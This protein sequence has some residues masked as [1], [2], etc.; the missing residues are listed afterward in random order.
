MG[1]LGSRERQAAPGLWLWSCPFTPSRGPRGPRPCP[2]A[3]G[4][5]PSCLPTVA[6]PSRACLTGP[7]TFR[8][9]GPAL[10]TGTADP[11]GSWTAP[12]LPP[13]QSRAVLDSAEAGGRRAEG[14]PGC[15][16]REDASLS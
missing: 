13:V 15:R 10:E 9:R 7:S 4:V 1:G 14:T 16:L 3:A 6:S 11:G 12:H 5:L 2:A 8:V